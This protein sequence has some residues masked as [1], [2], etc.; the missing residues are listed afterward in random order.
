M[1]ITWPLLASRYWAA[2]LAGVDTPLVTHWTYLTLMAV[3][4]VAVVV[5]AV[6]VREQR[7]AWGVLGLGL[8]LWTIGSIWQV[9]G[10]AR[11]ASAV[12]TPG[13]ADVLWLT[14]YPCTLLT[15]VALARP[16]LRS[17]RD[18][19]RARHDDARARRRRRRHR[20]R[21]AGR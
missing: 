9:A 1:P 8:T 11:T 10:R 5:R 4:S 15:F 17:A 21:A 19:A 12:V 3:P 16:W 20:G 6:R 18:H 13:P 2:L 14:V 7:F